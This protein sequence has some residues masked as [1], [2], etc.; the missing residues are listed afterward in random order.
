MSLRQYH[1][2]LGGPAHPG[3]LLWPG[4]P[5]GFPF[6]NKPG[7]SGIPDLKQEELENVEHEFVFKSRLFELWDADQKAEFDDINGKIVNG[8]YAL[9]KRSDHWDEEKKH[10]RIWLEW[11]QIYGLIPTTK[12][13]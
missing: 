4:T 7:A 11:C 8:W 2:E 10:F 12:Q 3:R 1:A 13:S 6:L 9:Q 5:E